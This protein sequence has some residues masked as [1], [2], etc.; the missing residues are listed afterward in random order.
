MEKVEKAKE[1]G[2]VGERIKVSWEEKEK[3]FLAA[4]TRLKRS[5]IKKIDSISSNQKIIKQIDLNSFLNV[6]THL[7][8]RPFHH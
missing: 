8:V 4:L 6:L 5:D 3:S 2:R 1:G 7:Q